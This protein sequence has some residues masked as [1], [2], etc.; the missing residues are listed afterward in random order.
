MPDL[1]PPTQFDREANDAGARPPGPSLAALDQPVGPTSWTNQAA[2]T[3]RGPAAGTS[4]RG[5]TGRMERAPASPQPATTQSR[6]GTRLRPPRARRLIQ[7]LL[8]LTFLGSS[9]ALLVLA[10][11]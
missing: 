8:G 2:P 7:L 4:A 9:Y 11:L 1:V 3:V 6:D 10:G 5:I